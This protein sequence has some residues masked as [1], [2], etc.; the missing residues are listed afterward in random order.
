MAEQKNTAHVLQAPSSASWPTRVFD[1]LIQLSL[2]MGVVISLYWGFVSSDRY[3][4]EA[5]VIIRK[6]DN[7]NLPSPD[8]TALVTAGAALGATRADQLL[9]RDYL[10]SLDMLKK[11][12]A[13]L[14]LRHH[15]SDSAHDVMS[16]LWFKDIEFFYRFYLRMV[17]VEY[18]DYAGVLRIRVQAYDRDTAHAIA[19]MLVEE[20]EDYMNV[21]G[22]E[23]AEAQIGFLTS[24]V[25]KAQERFQEASQAL[26]A[27]QNEKGLLSPT[28]T[29]ESINAIVASL[30]GQR[31]QLQTQLASLP[32]SL[33]RTHP[34]IL[35]L[36]QA[37]AAVD[38]Q[39][40]DEKAKLATPSGSTLNA[41]VEAF[42]RLQMQV[43]F[44][45]DLYKSA[46]LGL[47]KGRSDSLRLLEKVS[48]L[49]SPTVPEYPMEPR[50][51]YNIVLTLLIS[52]VV[53]G[54]LKLL[55]SIVLDHVD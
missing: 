20:G 8:L 45:Q 35:S 30:E 36:K 52:L 38:R 29:A 15:F 21:L 34:N 6:T 23:M 19:R 14:D 1:R 7:A 48:V 41:S 18:D 51:G 37:I 39:I 43:V 13:K 47:E 9:L 31:A 11:L 2:A 12:D 49:Q 44:T 33:E 32:K 55:E 4:S 26:L 10:L 46:L 53:A 24:Q 5:N 28:A 16:R 17:E 22:H 50:R 25:E 27:Y 3:V 54:T 40:D 42:Q